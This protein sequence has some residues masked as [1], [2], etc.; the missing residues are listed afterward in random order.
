MIVISN[1]LACIRKRI[2]SRGNE[3]RIL[4]LRVYEEPN[5]RNDTIQNVL[6]HFKLGD[7]QCRP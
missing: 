7:S 5:G 4:E 1:A 3:L 2:L 6:I